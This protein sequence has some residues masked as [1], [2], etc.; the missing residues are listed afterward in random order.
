MRKI[1]VIH[2]ITRLILGGAQQNTMETCANLNPDRYEA[3]IISGPETGTE[4]ELI[5]EVRER[6]IPLTIMPELVRSPHPLKDFRA[7]QKMAAYFRTVKPQIVHTH[8]S[9]AGILGRMAARRAGVPVIIHTVH[10]WGHHERQN[11]LYRNLFIRLEKRCVRYTDKLIVVSYLNAEKGLADSI[12]T[13][14]LYTTIHSSINLDDFTNR[15]WDT[16][17][18]KKSLGLD[19]GKPVI[20]TVG[21]L[22]PQKNPRDFI[23][24]AERVLKSKPDA[25]FVFVGDGPM[26]PE[27]EEEIRAAGLE[28]RIRLAGLRR[29]IPQMLSCFDVFILTSLWEGLP[30]VI[31]QAM[32]VGVPVV[33][34]AVDGVSEVIREGINGYSVQPGDVSRM[35]EHILHLLANESARS[36][37]GSQGRKT[38]ETDF[39]LKNMVARIEELYEDLLRQKKVSV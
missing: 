22:S 3:E 9:K 11:P 10:G 12:G 28:G 14:D 35:T 36:E 7:V 25:Q 5:S 1:K 39:S 34:N 4:G 2:P 23:Q 18:M 26:R 24:V 8:S 17:A 6:G 19:P 29:D 16:A 32:S 37:M 38:A 20:G 21:R 33:A 31:P 30:R 27:I 13:R 15:A